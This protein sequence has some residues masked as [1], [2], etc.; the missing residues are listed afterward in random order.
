MPKVL[1]HDKSPVDTKN[2]CHTFH[3]RDQGFEPALLITHL[4]YQP[5]SPPFYTSHLFRLPNLIPIQPPL[6]NLV[7]S[8]PFPPH[9]LQSFNP[10]PFGSHRL[11]P[12]YVLNFVKVKIEIQTDPASANSFLDLFVYYR[13]PITANTLIS[14]ECMPSPSCTNALILNP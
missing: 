7:P 6:T 1:P 9:T 8:P 2:K 14:E 4:C 10:K 5:F 3:S 12:P 11:S 13:S